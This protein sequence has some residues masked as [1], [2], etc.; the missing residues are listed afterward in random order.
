MNIDYKNIFNQV[1]LDLK[2]LNLIL[3]IF[4]KNYYT[5][6]EETEENINDNCLE[7]CKELIVKSNDDN[8]EEKFLRL[9]QKCN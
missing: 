6:F 2:K 3:D 9:L 7:Q 1:I 5:V 4:I 8:H